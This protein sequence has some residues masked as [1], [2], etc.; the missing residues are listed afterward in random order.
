MTEI[1][2][3]LRKREFLNAE[4]AD[5]PLRS[6]IPHS[7]LQRAC[8]YRKRRMVDQVIAKDCGA[9][10][11]YDPINIRYTTDI[12][13][14][15]VWMLHHASHYVVLGADGFAVAFEYGGSEHLAKNR[16]DEVRTAR[17]WYYTNAG[18]RIPERLDAWADE[19]VDLVR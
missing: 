8:A 14:M 16:V 17:K 9:I 6:P 19:V 2:K 13:N 11:L 5:K 15:Q 18:G 4:G 1:F 12:S 7:T 3:D 10:L